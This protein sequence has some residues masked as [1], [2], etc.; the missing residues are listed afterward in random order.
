MMLR[1]QQ[2]NSVIYLRFSS[3][4]EK[5]PVYFVLKD[6]LLW[7][8][9]ELNQSQELQNFLNYF[10]ASYWTMNAEDRLKVLE[11]FLF[12]LKS[13][14]EAKTKTVI[15]VL[16]SYNSFSD[17]NKGHTI[18]INLLKQISNKEIIIVTNTS[19]EGE[20][21]QN[22]QSIVKFDLDSIAVPEN[23]KTEVIS[24]LLGPLANDEL[25][26]LKEQTDANF[27]MISAY[28]EQRDTNFQ[29]FLSNY[30][31]LVSKEHKKWL[32][33]DQKK[34]KMMEEIMFYLDMNEP[35][36]KA[37]DRSFID[38]RFLIIRS[39]RT[40]KSINPAIREAFQEI[41]LEHNKIEEFLNE[42]GKE[43]KGTLFG[44]WFE[45]YLR[46]KIKGLINKEKVVQLSFKGKELSIFNPTITSVH[47]YG[48]NYENLKF[49]K[50]SKNAKNLLVFPFQKNFPILDFMYLPL[51]SS[52]FCSVKR[53]INSNH[54]NELMRTV[55]S[56]FFKY[57]VPTMATFSK[58]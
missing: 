17:L 53:E 21:L 30:K 57:S 3:E 40:I 47:Y 50:Y 31:D 16:D 36:L 38:T 8:Y 12:K 51:P 25:D 2:R 28:R 54:I 35:H 42:F 23:L 49:G 26:L 15:L 11:S 32:G 41:Y 5:N 37:M 24:T 9:P 55:K 45:F 58:I 44:N 6:L 48:S 19:E 13:L 46:N 33:N 27:E 22:K 14:V 43:M 34:Y 29:N 52:Y 18:V 7:F 1:S 10:L 4:F 20:R 56:Y 39:N